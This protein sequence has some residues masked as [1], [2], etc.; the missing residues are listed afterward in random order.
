MYHKSD[1]CVVAVVGVKLK[2]VQLSTPVSIWWTYSFGQRLHWW[3]SHTSLE[4]ASLSQT[5]SLFCP[6]QSR[7]MYRNQYK[8]TYST[9]VFVWIK[10]K[11]FI[12]ASFQQS[13][14]G[15]LHRNWTWINNNTCDKFR[16]S[17]AF[18]G[19]RM[20]RASKPVSTLTHHGNVHL[21]TSPCALTV[22]V[23]EMFR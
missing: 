5:L 10:K 7:L 2:S 19:L 6:T 23:F 22:Q 11:M 16:L 14:A 1:C 17:S 20:R 12:H 18:S 13:R 21:Y 3:I 9:V 8:L 4:S 15:L